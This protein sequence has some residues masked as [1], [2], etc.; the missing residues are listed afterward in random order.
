M[1]SRKTLFVMALVAAVSITFAINEAWT[2]RSRSLVGLS[3]LAGIEVSSSAPIGVM[4]GETPIQIAF[5]GRAESVVGNDVFGK[6]ESL[7]AGVPGVI[8]GDWTELV[9]NLRPEDP[10]MPQGRSLGDATDTLDTP[11]GSIFWAGTIAL[12]PT[13]DG[14]MGSTSTPFATTGPALITGG[15]GIYAGIL[16]TAQLNG[17]ISICIIDGTP[18]CGQSDNPLLPPG[19]GLRFDWQWILNGTIPGPADGDDDDDDDDTPATVYR[20]R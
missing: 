2:Q 3:D 14:A 18:G 12:A 1:K 9:A 11:D 10:M 8:I 15:T 13:A 20:R 16:G 4:S 5:I 17:R 6:A 19:L 7:Q